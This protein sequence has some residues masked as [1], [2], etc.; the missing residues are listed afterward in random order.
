MTNDHLSRD[1]IGYGAEPPHPHWPGDARVAVN[2]VINY[3]EGSEPSVPDGDPASES[4][5]TEGGSGAFDGRDLGAE[6]MFEFGSRVGI[7]RL[8]RIF[9]QARAP[10]T[11][12][13]CAQALARNPAVA[14]AIGAAGYDVC[15]HGLRW[16]RHQTLSEA[17][18]RAAIGDAYKTITDLVGYPPEGWYCRYAPTVNTRRIVVEHGGFLYDAD[19]YNDELPYWT[20][21]DGKN[22]LVVPYSLSTNDAKCSR[23]NL[24]TPDSFFQY[25]RDAFDMLYEEGATQP[26]FMTVGLHC[27]LTGHPG[28]ALGLRRFLQHIQAQDNVWICRRSDIAR[29]WA[30][31]HPAP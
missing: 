19:A 8:L 3:E 16:V 27:R 14:K 30:K 6:S 31:V 22:H 4:G 2:F 26:K 5:L 15:G 1:F 18:E 21:V 13:A 29:H 23:G 11:V 28:R 24:G 20:Q 7:W 9:E 10:L 25:L 17:E 12:F